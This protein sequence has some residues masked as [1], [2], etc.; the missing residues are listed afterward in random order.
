MEMT[1]GEFPCNLCLPCFPDQLEDTAHLMVKFDFFVTTAHF[2][3]CSQGLEDL[4]L[5]KHITVIIYHPISPGL[6]IT[7]K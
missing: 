4:T 2:L 3:W 7:M 6:L 5:H 1:A